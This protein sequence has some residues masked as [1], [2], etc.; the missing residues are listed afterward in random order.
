LKSAEDFRTVLLNRKP[1]IIEG[2]DLGTCLDKWTPQYL[3]DQVGVDTKVITALDRRSDITL[4]ANE[5]HRARE[6]F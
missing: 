3:C 2:L 6:Y 1:V 5:G 4:T